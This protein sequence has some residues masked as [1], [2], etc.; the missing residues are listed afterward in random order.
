MVTPDGCP[1][2]VYARLPAEPG[3]SAVLRHAG[4]RHRVLDLGAGA[5]RI[6]DPLARAGHDVVAVDVSAAMLERVQRARPVVSA[7]TDLHLD[8]RFDLVLLLSHLV[9]TADH[10]DRVD[11]LRA[12]ARHLAP[13]GLLL[14]QRH[15]P[16]RPL[17]LGAAQFGDVEVAIRELDTASWPR[18][19]AVTRYTVGGTSW[20][21]H[22]DAVV[23]D[24]T[25]LSHDLAS[26]GLRPLSFDGPWVTAER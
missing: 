25:A 8:E 24:D 13:D 9:N 3:L 14:I 1:V 5:G 10:D 23:L 26:A 4:G 20:D 2:E 7:I 15:D 6:A 16:D 22:W 17:G 11:L 18:V 21:Q 12:A 19:R